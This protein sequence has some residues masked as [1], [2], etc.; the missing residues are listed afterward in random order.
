MRHRLVGKMKLALE[1]VMNALLSRQA[2]EQ[3]RRHNT[4]PHELLR[5]QDSAWLQEA[6]CAGRVAA[7]EW[8]PTAHRSRHTASVVEVL[9]FD[10]REP[11]TPDRFMAHVHPDD[12]AAVKARTYGVRPEAPGYA[13]SFRFR[14]PDG[15]EVWLEETAM[16]EFDDDGRI[17]RLRG[18]NRD[19]TWQ[20]RATE[21]QG[22]LISELNHRMKNVLA[23]VAVAARATRESSSSIHEFVEA[24]EA[25]LRSLT[26]AHALLSKSQAVGLIE[27]L[28]RQLAPYALPSNTTLS[29]PDVAILPAAVECMSMVLHELV[30]NAAKYGAL[31]VPDGHVFVSWDHPFHGNASGPVRIEWR[32]IGGPAV[33]VEPLV[34]YGISLIRELIPHELGGAVDFAFAPE[35]LRCRIDIPREHVTDRSIAQAQH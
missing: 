20:K 12:R 2:R 9:G 6:L 31:S 5:E 30:T 27:L 21:H 13:V 19:I 28:H 17:V 33:T 26:D 25:R 10:L 8:D 32:E 34:G 22:L 3:P 15:R 35:G 4:E 1:I 18:V 7:F 16:A 24:F 11:V 14:R 29:G 23:R